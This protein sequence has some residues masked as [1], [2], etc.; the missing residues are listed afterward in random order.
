MKDLKKRLPGLLAC[1]AVAVPAWLLGKQVAVGSAVFAILLGLCC[2][3]AIAATSLG[4]QSFLGL[5]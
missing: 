2:W 1:L 3:V 5:W 4:M